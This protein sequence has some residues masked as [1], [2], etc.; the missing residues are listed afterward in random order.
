MCLKLQA[1]CCHLIQLA[2]DWL[3]CPSCR[4]STDKLQ[5]RCAIASFCIC[6]VL[7]LR[8][9]VALP[10]KSLA[11]TKSCQV[12]TAVGAGKLSKATIQA[13]QISEAQLSNPRSHT[14]VVG[15]C[16]KPIGS[17]CRQDDSRVVPTPNAPV[18]QPQ[19]QGED[20][21][22]YPVRGSQPRGSCVTYMSDAAGR[23]MEAILRQRNAHGSSQLRRTALAPEPV[24]S[25]AALQNFSG[26]LA[27]TSSGL[28]TR[29]GVGLHPAPS[30]PLSREA[31]HPG[32][33]PQ[34]AELA[35][36][37]SLYSEEQRIELLAQTR[38]QQLMAV[39]FPQ[40]NWS[41]Y[42]G[43]PPYPQ[44]WPGELATLHV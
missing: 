27:S 9:P 44:A 43:P 35:E 8:C 39:Q 18:L 24:L 22:L 6:R 14:A 38:M 16:L 15:W 30:V 34:Q 13:L 28:N 40:S 41:Y 20:V 29:S 1:H 12:D 42:G 5:H 11:T 23:G 7:F 4:F 26:S 21:D 32:I 2:C 10:T 33:Q 3:N 37:Y 17:S 25:V 31:G 36:Q 19:G